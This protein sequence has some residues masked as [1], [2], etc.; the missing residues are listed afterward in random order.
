MIEVNCFLCNGGHRTRLFRQ[1]GRD[2]YLE[3][4]HRNLTTRELSWYVCND[5]GFVYRSPMLD[6]LEFER[7]YSSYEKD[8][9]RDRTPDAYFDSIV[10]LPREQSENKQ[11]IMW[12]GDNLSTLRPSVRLSAMRVLDVGCGGGTLL[13]TIRQELGMT[14]LFGVELNS[15]YAGLAARR[16]RVEL[17]NEQYQKGMFD[18]K[19]DLIINTKVLE[20]VLHPTLFLSEMVGDLNDNG[21]LFL[22]VPDISDLFVLPPSHSRFFIPHIFYYSINTLSEL[23][24][25]CNLAICTSR[26]VVGPSGRAYLQV[27]AEGSSV[28]QPP[29]LA[30]YDDPS[31]IIERVRCRPLL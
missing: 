14:R 5:C 15:A 2:P 17:K 9:F 3:I 6:K 19:F 10:N 11:K 8:V 1:E 31:A 22:E 13:Y 24:R 27:L 21:I 29:K 20:H 4:V 28:V 12:L 23:L 16:A 26:T 25:R 7:L 30:P 18:Q